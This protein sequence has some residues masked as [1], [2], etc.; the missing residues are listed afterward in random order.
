MLSHLTFLVLFVFALRCL[1]LEVSLFVFHKKLIHFLIV[2]L[3]ILIKILMI[4]KTLLIE[5]SLDILA[6]KQVIAR[7]ILAVFLF[8]SNNR[9]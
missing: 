1:K 7:F 3:V 2:F 6:E 4:V 9:L 8:F 5:H